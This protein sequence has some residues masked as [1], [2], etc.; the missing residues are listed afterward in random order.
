MLYP[1][2][3]KIMFYA[4]D[5]EKGIDLIDFTPWIRIPPP[6]IHF[7]TSPNIIDLKQGGS[8]TVDL[9][10]NSTK[11]FG[12]TVYLSNGN[13]SDEI[14]S[15]FKYS[16]LHVPPFGIAITPLT[17]YASS[18]APIKQY[19]ILLFAKWAFPSIHLAKSKVNLVVQNIKLPLNQSSSS[20]STYYNLIITLSKPPSLI[21]N[22]SVTWNKLGSPILFIYGIIAGISPW[23]YK[24]IRDYLKRDSN[25][26]RIGQF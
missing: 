21:D 14:K 9:I 17:I 13:Q 10:V 6:E 15:E 5:K 20:G 1:D 3:Y 24:K 16:T 19:T 23:I 4:E 8:A 7:S 12:P 18:S 2:T 26:R 25:Q 22:I 11:G